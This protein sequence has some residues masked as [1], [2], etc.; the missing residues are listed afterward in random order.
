MSHADS[1]L[2]I[3][4]S[5]PQKIPKM[6][7]T[8][9]LTDLCMFKQKLC[10]V[11]GEILLLACGSWFPLLNDC[12]S[13]SFPCINLEFTIQHPAFSRIGVVANA[14]KQSVLLQ[15]RNADKL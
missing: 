13:I 7:A 12:E 8:T 5:T 9:H 11:S 4:R 2:I 15:R 1:T 3:G 10:E 14:G 6:A